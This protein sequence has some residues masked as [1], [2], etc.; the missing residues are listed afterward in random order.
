MSGEVIKIL[1]N[2][3]YRRPTADTQQD[4]NDNLINIHTKGCVR[5]SEAYVPQKLADYISRFQERAAIREFDGNQSRVEA[6]LGAIEE[7]LP[8]LEVINDGERIVIP[9]NVAAKY[10]WWQNGQ[11][12]E[13]TLCE[14]GA[15]EETISKY[16]SRIG[17][18]SSHD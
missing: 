11:S 9:N 7:V 5:P 18:S 15:G 2:I 14:L 1:A 13:A 3:R 6:E 8:F 16:V 12:I 10:K 4:A 17:G